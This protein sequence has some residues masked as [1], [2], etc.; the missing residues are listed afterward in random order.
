[1]KRP[2][3]WI[4]ASVQQIMVNESLLKRHQL[5]IC[6]AKAQ[7]FNAAVHNASNKEDAPGRFPKDSLA[8][9]LR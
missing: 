4:E 2:L 6:Q 1:M 8:W 5:F 9:Q 3:K 7:V